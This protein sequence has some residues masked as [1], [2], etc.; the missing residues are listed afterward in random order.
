[1]DFSQTNIFRGLSLGSIRT[2][3]LILHPSP[4]AIVNPCFSFLTPYEPAPAEPQATTADI[5]HFSVRG[6]QAL[7][8][9]NLADILADSFHSR[10][11]IAGWAYPLL[12]LGIYEDLRNRLRSTPPQYKC[13]VAVAAIPTTT[14]VCEQI[15][16]TV[17]IAL[18]FP[19]SWQPR[20]SKY[21]YISNLAVKT[22]CRRQGAAKQLLLACER[23]A[24][25]WG[26]SD[27]YLHV[28]ENNHQARQLYLKSGYQLRQVEPNYGAWL[29]GHPKRLLLQ[30]HLPGTE[31]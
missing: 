15:A 10:T 30:K 21:P 11:G 7:D 19:P 9:T 4:L 18:R 31:K 20:G 16:G 2:V 3:S 1:M 8:L 25:E 12:R 27:L 28:L 14:G 24:L 13:L 6:A 23:T 5:A 26:Y 17:E 29:L 22:S